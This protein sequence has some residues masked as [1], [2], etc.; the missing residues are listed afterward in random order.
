MIIWSD[1]IFY[2][3]SCLYQAVQ[4]LD[5]EFKILVKSVWYLIY[6]QGSTQFQLPQREELYSGTKYKEWFFSEQIWAFHYF[7]QAGLFLKIPSAVNWE[8]ASGF[9][10]DKFIIRVDLFRN[11][12]EPNSILTKNFLPLPMQCHDPHWKTNLK[13]ENWLCLKLQIPIA[14]CL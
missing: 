11:F 2:S 5:R 9:S 7:L 3:P 4:V 8:R 10:F 13:Y 1:D 6:L 12:D 14:N